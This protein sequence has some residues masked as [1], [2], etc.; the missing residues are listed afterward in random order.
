[1]VLEHVSNWNFGN[2]R[3]FNPLLLA[4]DW[5]KTADLSAES[6]ANMLGGIR[7]KVLDGTH[8]VIEKCSPIKQAAE[9]GDLAGDSG[10]NF[11]FIVFQQLDKCRH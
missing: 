6:S 7:D 4:Q 2:S 10:S 11:G 8:N 3:Q 1:M 5:R 9:A